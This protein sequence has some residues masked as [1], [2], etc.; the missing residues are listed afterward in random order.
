MTNDRIVILTLSASYLIIVLTLCVG[1]FIDKVD[2][3]QIFGIL[4]IFFN[5]GL[6]VYLGVIKNGKDKDE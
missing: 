6:L 4:Q 1:L 2:N 5:S 3:K